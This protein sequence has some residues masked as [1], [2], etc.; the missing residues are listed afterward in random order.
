MVSVPST[1]QSG[2]Q[3]WFSS[4]LA[5]LCYL[6]L[7]KLLL[8]FCTN[9]QYGYYPDELYYIAAGEHLDW[10][11]AEG[12][13]LTPAIANLSRWLLG[14]A[15]FAIRFFPALSGAATVI[16]TGL[17]ARELGGGRL[18]QVIAAIAVIFVP[19]YLFL[20][21]ILTMNAFEPLLWALCAYFA[22]YILKTEQLSLWAIAGVVVGIGLMNK[23]S[24]AFF[25]ASLVLGI[26]IT[27]ARR[28]LFSRWFL[29]GGILA[30]GI[31]SPT[32]LWQINHQWPFLEHQRESSLYEKK[33]LLWSAIDLILQ[34]VI[35]TNPGAVPVWGCGLYYYL[36]TRDGKPYRP[37]GWAYIITLGWF[38][39]FE[40]RFYYLLPIYPMLLAA[41]AVFLEPTLQ[42][43][44]VWKYTTL[45]VLLASG[46]ILVPVSLPILPIESLIRY[47][48]AI[49]RPP[50]LSSSQQEDASEAPWHFRLM[51]GWEETVVWIAQIYQQ[52]SPQEQSECAILAWGYGNAGAID[53]WGSAYNLPKAISGHTGYYFW[54]P[55]DYSGSVVLSIGGDPTFLQQTFDSV[56]LVTTLTYEDIVGVTDELTLYLC[57]DIKRPLSEMWPAFKYYFKQPSTNFITTS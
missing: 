48:N 50:T 22:I 36:F 30:I 15:L 42:R 44:L 14:D 33:G 32:I 2:M 34:Q 41:G 7:F 57:K 8:H 17:I 21:T 6:G 20:H 38:L 37:L 53:F 47:S 52:L 54:G 40:G 9:H 23:F 27:P 46:V 16:L 4:D 5:I 10:G 39:F 55:Q 28:L 11:F 49:Y 56:E 45:F 12:S 51:L 25:A 29:L 26:L 43:Y 24:I 1:P 35:L 31:F 13:P 19:G 18:A 3:Q